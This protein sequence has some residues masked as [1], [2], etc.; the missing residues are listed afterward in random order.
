[1]NRNLQ[2][3]YNSMNMVPWLTRATQP[4]NQNVCT[5]HYVLLCMMY[6][7][8]II[9]VCLTYPTSRASAPQAPV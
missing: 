6:D 5:V 4:Q 1:M 9:V 8:T 7:S 3:L 2:N